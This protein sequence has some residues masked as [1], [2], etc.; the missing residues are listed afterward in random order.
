MD[1]TAH[2]FLFGKI[3]IGPQRLNVLMS[4]LAINVSAVVV[5]YWNAYMYWFV[6]KSESKYLIVHC[7]LWLLTFVFFCTTA[8][9]EPGLIPH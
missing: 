1:S 8:F 3:Y 2:R 5:L 9:R 7:I 4:F 6:E